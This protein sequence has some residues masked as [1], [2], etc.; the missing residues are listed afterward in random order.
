[1]IVKDKDC[2]KK[3]RA[4]DHLQQ[5][6]VVFTTKYPGSEFLL[7][8]YKQLDE[9]RVNSINE[10]SSNILSDFEMILEK[11]SKKTG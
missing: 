11:E 1:M 9:Y 3:L 6:L 10:G 5:I 2:T 7:D 8:T 4:I